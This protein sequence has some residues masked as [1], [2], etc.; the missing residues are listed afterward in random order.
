MVK[1]TDHALAQLRLIYDYIAHDSPLY[2]KRVSEE[3]VR[4]TV[5]LDELPYQGRKVPE[6]N[7]EYIRELG[8]YSYRIIYEI[9]TD[10]V[11]ILAVIHKRRDF[12]PEDL[13]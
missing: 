8:L 7:E 10:H 3:M 5:G 2:A 12:A 1:W 4:K 11:E 9:K 13:P 6:L